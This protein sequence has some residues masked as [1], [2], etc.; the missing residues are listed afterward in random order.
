MVSNE[1]IYEHKSG[2]FHAFENNKNFET[3]SK[4][5]INIFFLIGKI[6][7][8]YSYTFSFKKC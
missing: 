7:F 4:N 5:K 6:K 1:I 3:D 8:V 2:N